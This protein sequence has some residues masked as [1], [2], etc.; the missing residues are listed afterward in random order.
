MKFFR[1]PPHA[2]A[3]RNDE[4]GDEPARRRG[5]QPPQKAAFS[6]RTAPPMPSGSMPG[7][8]TGS[9]TRAVQGGLPGQDRPRLKSRAPGEATPGKQPA[10]QHRSAGEPG[11]AA[12]ART[13]HS[14][15]QPTAPA[16]AHASAARATS[17]RR[18]S[19]RV[20]LDRTPAL[21]TRGERTL[22]SILLAAVVGM[23][24]FLVRYREHVDAHFQARA[25]AVPLATA[26]GPGAA[27]AGPLL[28]YL[29]NDDTG[30]L[31]E[32]PLSFVLPEDPNTRARVVLEKLLSEYT[33]P[34]STH[35]LKAAAPGVESVQEVYLSPVPGTSRPAV[36]TGNQPLLA[37][38]D[39]TASFAHLHPSGI[40]PETL[41]LLSI[42]ATLHANLPVVAEVHFLVDGEP[43][44]TL[45]GHADLSRT[46]LAGAAQMSPGE[47][48]AT[49]PAAPAH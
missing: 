2:E 19:F 18:G 1:K 43:R 7:P 29:A 39:L 41:T 33:A 46:Y 15:A 23:S 9:T 21:I 45:A 5:W 13:P 34:G 16:P 47:A 6:G 27:A 4:A 32:R 37:V 8:M 31:I 30:A 40:E 24:I 36:S 11:A 26:A 20:P 49:H 14:V 35:P 3:A 42:I 44:A 12:G 38:V 28:L 10:S 48:F 25:L 17:R 22:F